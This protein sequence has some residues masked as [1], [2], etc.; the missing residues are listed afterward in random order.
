MYMMYPP[1]QSN[2]YKNKNEKLTTKE[3]NEP[4]HLTSYSYVRL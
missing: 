1:F 3:K 4:R 2:F